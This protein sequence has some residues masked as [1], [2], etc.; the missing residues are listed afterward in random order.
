MDD[1]YDRD[2]AS[3]GVS[4]YGAYVRQSFDRWADD[5]WCVEDECSPAKLH[6]SEDE[7]LIWTWDR[8]T[9][10]VMVP[11]YVKVPGHVL[12]VRLGRDY[13]GGSLLGA[14]EVAAPMPVRL[15]LR[16]RGWELDDLEE[17][18]VGPERLPA[19]LSTV[20]LTAPLVGRWDG[21]TIRA[22]VGDGLVRAAQAAVRNTCVRLNETFGDVLDQIREGRA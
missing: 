7:W 14:I 13:Y 10:P 16:W 17:R 20:T 4:R 3:D 12:A 9:G 19:A 2:N 5:A 11:A 21:P 1:D 6:T 22:E 15:G 18:L 8:A